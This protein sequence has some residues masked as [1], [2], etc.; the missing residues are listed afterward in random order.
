MDVDIDVNSKFDPLK[1]FPG[2]V[3]ASLYK[4]KK[5]S[6]HPCGVYFQEIAIDPITRLAAI[7]YEAAEE[8]GAFK[9]DF[10]HLHVYDHFSSREEIKEF[11]KIPPD[12][13]LLQIPS[14]V[15]Q[16]FQLSKHE[17][18]L[19]QV[20]PSSIM[21][22]GDVLALI[23]PQKRFLL[24]YYLADRTKAR[25]LLYSR[26]AAEGYA[27]KKAHAVAY[28]LVVVLQLHLIQGGIAF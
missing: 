24:K 8:L 5:L 15:R 27:F 13:A 22:L 28:A 20:K 18:I 10:L 21:E 2:A 26:D 16:L 4:D 3:K 1:V 6:P 17:D 25:S 23:R 12:W 9:V 11:L 19:A 7:P 14:V